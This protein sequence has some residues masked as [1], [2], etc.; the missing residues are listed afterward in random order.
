MHLK[1]LE[2]VF[3]QSI[4]DKQK[5]AALSLGMSNKRATMIHIIM[6]QAIKKYH[7]CFG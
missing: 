3:Y 6:P 2:Q 4:K 5:E 1:H 7:A